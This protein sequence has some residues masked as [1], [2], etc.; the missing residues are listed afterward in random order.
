MTRTFGLEL[1]ESVLNNYSQ[2]FYKY[3]PFRILLKVDITILN[4]RIGSGSARIHIILPDPNPS[5]DMINDDM[6]PVMD[7]A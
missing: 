7:P 6:Y 3:Q 2:V 5:Y 4:F 1:S